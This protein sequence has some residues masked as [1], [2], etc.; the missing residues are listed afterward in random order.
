MNTQYHLKG[1]GFSGRAVRLRELKPSEVEANFTSA[2]KLVGGEGTQLE[3]AKTT[4]R[5]GARLMIESYSNPCKDPMATEGIVWKKGESIEDMD[6]VF[7]AKD[8]LALE[9]IFRQC[10]ELVV[11]DLEAI[12]SGA[13]PVAEG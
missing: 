12:T 4:W 11:S 1:A 10:Y 8:V 3:L 5:N 2:A 7:K 13:I 9:A 6:A